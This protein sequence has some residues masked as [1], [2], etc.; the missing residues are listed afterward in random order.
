M[1]ENTAVRKPWERISDDSKT[2]SLTASIQKHTMIFEQTSNYLCDY[3]SAPVNKNRCSELRT[4]LATAR[5]TQRD[6]ES[7]GSVQ[8]FVANRL[9]QLYARA[10][11]RL[12]TGAR[13]RQH[14]MPMAVS[15]LMDRISVHTHCA[16]P[17]TSHYPPSHVRFP[18]HRRIL[19][20]PLSM[21]IA[22]TVRTLHHTV[23][24]LLNFHGDL[25]SHRSDSV[26]G[27]ASKRRTKTRTKPLKVALSSL[28][29]VSQR[30]FFIS[31]PDLANRT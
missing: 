2:E 19:F 30:G 12:L 26:E 6:Y 27:V 18:S 11:Y 14:A 1:V 21:S 25:A 10:H 8:Y 24:P 4:R 7:V 3:R 29:T 28:L 22:A 13:H 20:I 17:Q 15:R 16:P 31:F 23:T 5:P 9:S